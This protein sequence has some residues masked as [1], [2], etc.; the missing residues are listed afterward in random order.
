M[1]TGFGDKKKGVTLAY[2][3]P[4]GQTI[5]TDLYVETFKILQKRFRRVRPH[6]NAAEIL[7]NDSARQDK[8][9]KTQEAITKLAWT[10]L[11]HPPCSPDLDPSD[12][13]LFGALKGVIRGKMFRSDNEATEEVKK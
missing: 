7:Q 8:S 5:N 3:F 1:P 10:V 2:V 6:R 11:L 4:R 12:F 13:H 9:F